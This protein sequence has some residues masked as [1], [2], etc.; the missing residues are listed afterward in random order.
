MLSRPPGCGKTLLAKAL[1]SE[2]NVPFYSM[3]GTEFI[4]VIGG[5]G[6][7]RVRD[8]FAEARKNPS[9]IIYIDEIDAIG[10]KR[11]ESSNSSND[12]VDQTLN[13]LLSEMDGLE[14]KANVIILAS[15]NRPD[16]LDKALLRPGRFDRHITIDLP[17]MEERKEILNVHMSKLKLHKSVDEAFVSDLSQ[18]TTRMSGKKCIIYPLINFSMIKHLNFLLKFR[19]RFS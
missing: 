4:E 10:K 16:I 12:E 19:S 15:T 11:S 18:L 1:A 6:A 5:V 13:Q 2:S 17:T 14:S 9:A 8:L 7:A 3:A